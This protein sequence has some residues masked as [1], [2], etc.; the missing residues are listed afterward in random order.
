MPKLIARVNECFKFIETKG[1]VTDQRVT[2]AKLVTVCNGMLLSEFNADIAKSAISMVAG[3]FLA[4][5][6]CV[7]QQQGTPCF[8]WP[9]NS[10]LICRQDIEEACLCV[11]DT[12]CNILK[13]KE[14][15]SPP[16]SNPT[17]AKV[18]ENPENSVGVLGMANES[19]IVD[20]LNAADVNLP[21]CPDAVV[22]KVVVMNT[23]NLTVDQ[24]RDN[25]VICSLCKEKISGVLPGSLIE[26]TTVH[27]CE[28]CLA[29]MQQTVS[30][31][32]EDVVKTSSTLMKMPRKTRS[33]K[34]P[35]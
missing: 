34:T 14:P 3:K 12:L 29:S 7:L 19:N 6:L 30:C 4:R 2:V 27:A 32:V 9:I 26:G 8:Q 23:E 28:N 31:H 11:L 20:N 13:T 24:E 22:P 17:S 35:K 25:C 16:L 1:T 15:A 5:K 21:P 18:I 10:E 33:N